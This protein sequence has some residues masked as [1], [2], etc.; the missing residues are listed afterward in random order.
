MRKKTQTHKT[1][2]SKKGGNST[3]FFFLL[4]NANDSKVLTPLAIGKVFFFS[5]YE[6]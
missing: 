3:S 4:K 1:Q 5:N 2:M 6:T